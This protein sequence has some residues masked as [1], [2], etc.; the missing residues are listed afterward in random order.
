MAEQRGFTAGTCHS[1]HGY[2]AWPDESSGAPYLTLIV[3][4]LVVDPTQPREAPQSERPFAAWVIDGETRPFAYQLYGA[5]AG[6]EP[7]LR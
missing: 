5:S 1:V 2:V 7:I 6:W 3:R 4:G